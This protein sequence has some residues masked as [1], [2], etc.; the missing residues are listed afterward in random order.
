M[1]DCEESEIVDKGVTIVFLFATL[2]NPRWGLVLRIYVGI[3]R[4][5]KPLRQPQ[6][7]LHRV[8]ALPWLG[9]PV[10]SK[11]CWNSSPVGSDLTAARVPLCYLFQKGAHCSWCCFIPPVPLPVILPKRAYGQASV[12]LFSMEDLLSN[13]Y[14]IFL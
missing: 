8:P 5:V 10:G 9:C 1:V 12:P 13:S 3:R 4:Y 11:A 6:S 2:G 7:Q 14:S